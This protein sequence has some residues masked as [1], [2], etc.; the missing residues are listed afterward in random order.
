MTPEKK[1]GETPH[2][3]AGS[4][5]GRVTIYLRKKIEEHY[6]LKKDKSGNNNAN[7]REENEIRERATHAIWC[8]GERGGIMPE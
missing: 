7:S 6:P 1:D 8:K 3:H 4:A 5:W 2:E